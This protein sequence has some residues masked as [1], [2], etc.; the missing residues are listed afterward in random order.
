MSKMKLRLWVVKIYG[1]YTK[2]EYFSPSKNM[3]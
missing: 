2:E 3:N 1:G